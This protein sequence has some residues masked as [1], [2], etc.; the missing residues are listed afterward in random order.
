LKPSFLSA[1]EGF[2]KW[3]VDAQAAL[4]TKPMNHLKAMRDS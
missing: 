2:R 1:N 3:S 4:R